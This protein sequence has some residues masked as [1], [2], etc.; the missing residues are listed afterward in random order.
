MIRIHPFQ[1]K[2]KEGGERR[3]QFGPMEGS[4]TWWPL[5]SSIAW[6]PLEGSIAW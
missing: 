4:I 1:E 6:W 2:E 5:E 3:S